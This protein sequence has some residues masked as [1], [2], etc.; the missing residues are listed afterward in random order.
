MGSWYTSGT[1]LRNRPHSK[2]FG[3]VTKARD[4]VTV[5]VR[6]TRCAAHGVTLALPR[7]RTVEERPAEVTVRLFLRHGGNAVPPLRNMTDSV[8]MDLKAVLRGIQGV[9]IFGPPPTPKPF[10]GPVAFLLRLYRRLRP[11]S[12]LSPALTPFCMQFLVSACSVGLVRKEQSLLPMPC[13]GL[14]G[15]RHLEQSFSDFPNPHR[16]VDKK[17]TSF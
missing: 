2:F 5:P 7:I 1:R 14:A 11:S 9:K 8:E 6:R 10:R 16:Y 13:L 15:K 3:T 17:S 4:K 12:A